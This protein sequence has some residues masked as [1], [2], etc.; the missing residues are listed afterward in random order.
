MRLRWVGDARDYVKWDCV[1]ENA[2]ELF[3]SYVPMLR[4]DVDPVCRHK[5]V[6]DH[7]D[8]RKDLSQFGDLFP[9]RYSLFEFDGEEY[10]K[11]VADRYFESVV[12]KLK[13]IQR[14]H[15]VLVFIDPD[16]GI[17][18]A[19]GAKD[20]HLRWKDIRLVWGTLRCEDKLIIYQHA[21][22]EKDWIQRLKERTARELGIK[23][24]AEPYCNQELAKDVCFLVLNGS[25]S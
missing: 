2:D 1:F 16:T 6:K 7:F 18:P 5:K 12:E 11:S 19:S 21:P 3:V 9:N 10:S 13:E 15:R 23:A 8:K 24:V 25:K 14:E 22:R 20:E 4:T 17:E